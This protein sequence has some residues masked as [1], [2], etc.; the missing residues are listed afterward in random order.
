M[1]QA[2]GGAIGFPDGTKRVKLVQAAG[3]KLIF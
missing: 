3:L 1:P 2:A